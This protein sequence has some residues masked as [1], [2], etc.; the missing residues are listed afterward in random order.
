MPVQGTISERE[1]FEFGNE[2]S[3]CLRYLK[4]VIRSGKWLLCL[5]PISVRF[6]CMKLYNGCGSWKVIKLEELINFRRENGKHCE[7]REI[8]YLRINPTILL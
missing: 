4:S 6:V 5:K 3:F 8:Y 2:V 7:I 1:S